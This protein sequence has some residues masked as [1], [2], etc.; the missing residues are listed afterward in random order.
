MPD[1]E[2]YRNN[3]RIIADYLKIATTS[4]ALAAADETG[5]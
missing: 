5:A 3:W 2:T 4:V 1:Y